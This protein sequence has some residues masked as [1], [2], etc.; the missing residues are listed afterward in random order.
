MKKY[1]LACVV[2]YV[3]VVM[4]SFAIH[5]GI[6]GSQYMQLTHLFRPMP[7]SEA[8]MGYMF[9]SYIP[10]VLGA[11]WI[12]RMGVQRKPW[13]GQGVRFGLALWAVTWFHS[14]LVYF[15]LQPWPGD[16]VAKQIVLSGISAVIQ[17]I[18][19]AAVY[20]QEAAGAS[21]GEAAGA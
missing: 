3:V 7:G 16:L 9:L 8:Y 15:S 20:R 6:L 10:Y 19:V 1:L 18:A 17:G 12:Y 2:L 11:V 4:L 21:R 5:E 14:Y 13:L